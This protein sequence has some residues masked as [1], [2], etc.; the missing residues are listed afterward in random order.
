MRNYSQPLKSRRK[1]KESMVL[2]CVRKKMRLLPFALTLVPMGALAFEDIAATNAVTTEYATEVKYDSLSIEENKSDELISLNPIIESNLLDE[3]VDTIPSFASQS[4]A[5][6]KN[7]PRKN[8]SSNL[9]EDSTDA[10]DFG[11]A[12]TLYDEDTPKENL[13][14]SQQTF[15]SLFS[16]TIVFDEAGDTR[17]VG[18]LAAKA[19]DGAVISDGVSDVAARFPSFV[20][21]TR[22][23]GENESFVSDKTYSVASDGTIYEVVAGDGKKKLNT[24]Q[25]SGWMVGVADEVNASEDATAASSKPATEAPAAQ[26][27][28]STTGVGKSASFG[29]EE[30]EAPRFVSL[31]VKVNVPEGVNPASVFLRIAGTSWQVSVDEEGLAHFPDLPNGS[32]IQF[33]VW[34]ADNVLSRRLVPVA[35]STFK[36]DYTIDMHRQSD[37]SLFAAAA[38]TQQVGDNS[39]FCGR[40]VTREPAAMLGAR[41]WLSHAGTQVFYVS[42]EHFPDAKLTEVTEDGRFCVFN[43]TEGVVEMTVGLLNGI[44][45]NFTVHLSPTT[46]ES[47]IDLDMESGVYRPVAGLELQDSTEVFNTAGRDDHRSPFG[48]TDG[49]RWMSGFDSA[50]WTNVDGYYLTGERGYAAQLV[51]VSPTEKPGLFF[52]S[53]GQELNEV[54]WSKYADDEHRAFSLLGRG[55]ILI[56]RSGE[57]KTLTNSRKIMSLKLFSNDAF[58]ELEHLSTDSGIDRSLGLAVVSLNAAGLETEYKDLR[59]QL[60]DAWTNVV[61]AKMQFIPLAA[62]VK[63]PK[64]VRGFFPNLARG[65]YT[66]LVTNAEGAVKWMDVVRALPGQTQLISIGE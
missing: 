49:R 30:T 48:N 51:E 2:R 24:E 22:K 23:V 6:T 42:K 60:R 7:T 59:I 44:R 31:T 12:V 53:A 52:F 61:L 3:E 16:D 62:D 10:D 17:F 25:G 58:A 21:P 34:D 50:V 47:Q 11:E 26:N 57:M 37:V 54:T 43:V 35:V 18:S 55:S 33:L 4:L 56:D 29:N 28:A 27:N 66:L 32:K 15:R 64:H 40:L 1:K 36:T 39:G 41:V 9:L 63:S 46:F 20:K 65:H 14:R 19:V 5:K 13:L 38:G 45:R 8:E